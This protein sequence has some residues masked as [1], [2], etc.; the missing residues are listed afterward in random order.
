MRVC[1]TGD[2]LAL[3]D[4]LIVAGDN[5]AALARLPEESF[6]LVYM[7]PPF[8]TGRVRTRDTLAVTLL[9]GR[10]AGRVRRA[11]LPLAAAAEPELRRCL[12]RITSSS[13]PRG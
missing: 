5:A 8:N 4:D 1:T 10:G 6:D 7:D 13:S 11:P 9:G 2:E 12:R 3:D